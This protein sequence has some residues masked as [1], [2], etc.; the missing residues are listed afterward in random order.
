[1]LAL[2]FKTPYKKKKKSILKEHVRPF[3][4]VQEK[5]KLTFVDCKTALLQRLTVNK[6]YAGSGKELVEGIFHCPV[7]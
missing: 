6:N 1:M 7:W 2:V 3:L 4:K 5:L